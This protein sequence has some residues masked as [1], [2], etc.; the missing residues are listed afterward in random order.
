MTCSLTLI[1]QTTT[2]PDTL[3][4]ELTPKDR[5]VMVKLI[6]MHRQKYMQWKWLIAVLLIVI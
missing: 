3:H 4:Q 2:G 6:F 1:R 5:S